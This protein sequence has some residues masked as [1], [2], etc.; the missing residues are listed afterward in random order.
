M[1]GTALQLADGHLVV[2]SAVGAGLEAAAH[3]HVLGRFVLRRRAGAAGSRL[4][5]RGL[6]GWPLLVELVSACGVSDDLGRRRRR[7]EVERDLDAARDRLAVA[8][9]PA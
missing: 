5:G 8:H 4:R 9:A 3:L 7:C 6:L 1:R 2:G